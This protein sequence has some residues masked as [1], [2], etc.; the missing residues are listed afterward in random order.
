[1]NYNGKQKE[2]KI[3]Y[4]DEAKTTRTGQKVCWTHEDLGGGGWESNNT[5]EILF[6]KKIISKT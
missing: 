5:N 2:I 4:Y 3:S 6:Q 1:M